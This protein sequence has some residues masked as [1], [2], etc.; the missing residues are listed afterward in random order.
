[1]LSGLRAGTPIYVFDKTKPSVSIGEVLSVSSPVN[2]YGITY[3]P[4]GMNPPSMVVDIKARVDGAEVNY[5]KMPATS[6]IAD[7]GQSGIVV[8]ESRDAILNEIDGFKKISERILADVDRH[9][10]IV[11]K[12]DEMTLALNPQAQKEAEHTK[13]IAELRSQ[14][15]SLSGQIEQVSGM[16]AQFLNNKA[17]NKEDK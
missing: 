2:Q 7:F 3:T 1:M 16:L 11:S 14:V 8:S 9:R 15:S 12:C 10:A 17:K 13:D 6:T 4:N 5:T